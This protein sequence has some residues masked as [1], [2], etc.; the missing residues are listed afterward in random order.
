MSQTELLAPPSSQEIVPDR[1]PPPPPTHNDT[2]PPPAIVDGI[3]QPRIQ[4]YSHTG[5][6]TE[7]PAVP[8]TLQHTSQPSIT[9]S[10]TKSNDQQ[11]KSCLLPDPVVVSSHEWKDNMKN[12]PLPR[13]RQSRWEQ[14][15]STEGIPQL[16]FTLYIISIF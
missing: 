11:N 7:L 9:T 4:Q 1:T 10:H 5:Y 13:K 14:Q 16:I 12:R 6:T 2:T 3:H 15:P 8:N